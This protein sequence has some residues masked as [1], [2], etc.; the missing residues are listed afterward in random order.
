LVEPYVDEHDL[1]FVVVAG[2]KTPE[3]YG[4]QGYPQTVLIDPD[5]KVAWVGRPDGLSDG[6]VKKALKGAKKPKGEFLSVRI[7]GDEEARTAKARALALDG[8]LSGASKEI[9]AVLADAKSTDEQK[10]SAT[11]IREE[12]DARL[13]LLATQAE[14]F[15]K[16][17]DVDKAVF[18]L[19]AVKKALPSSEH[20]TAATKRLAEIAADEKLMKEVEAGKALERLK[21][22]IRPL[23]KD[24]A[25][26]KIEEFVKKHAGTRAAERASTLLKK[27][28]G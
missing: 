11:A 21:D 17:R 6:L 1:P 3:A 22:Q 20:G 19:E 15:V 5:G 28:K 27:S 26:P 18:V 14:G 12:I 24:K 16:T 7:D 10:Q 4:V 9:D 2:S 8:D 23:K 13:K 25:K